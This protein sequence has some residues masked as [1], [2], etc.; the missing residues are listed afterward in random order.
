MQRRIS[1]PQENNKPVRHYN[2]AGVQILRSAQDDKVWG[3]RF[4]Q[5]RS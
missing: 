4:A 5:S 3:F 1:I 2:I